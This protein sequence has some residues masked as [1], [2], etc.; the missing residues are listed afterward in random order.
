MKTKKTLIFSLIFIFTFSNVGLPLTLHV[1][2]AMKTISF[3]KCEMCNEQESSAHSCCEKNIPDDV[4]KIKFEKKC[5]EAK[6]LG[7]PLTEKFLASEISKIDVKDFSHPEISIDKILN[8][9]AIIKYCTTSSSPP[10][11]INHLYL[12]NSILLI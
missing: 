6:V 5:C 12:T 7:S 2:S 10:F 8:D 4:Y 11:Y 9:E 3:D 1:C